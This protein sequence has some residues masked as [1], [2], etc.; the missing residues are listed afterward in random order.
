MKQIMI[1]A[2]IVFMV[3]AVKPINAQDMNPKITTF[4]MFEGQAEEAMTFYTSLF[5]DSEIVGITKYGPDGPGGPEAEGTVQHALFTLKGQ[6]YM[7]IDS[8]GHEFTF[9]PSISLFVQCD[10]EE[11]LET[12]YE[13]LSEGGEVLMPLNNYGFS[14]KFGWVNDR[15]GVS[16]QLNYGQLNFE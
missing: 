6:Q 4:L 3:S 9:T 7:A 5:D 8:F 1:L 11:E 12:L 13:K 15:F 16:W 2:A 14:T 10:S